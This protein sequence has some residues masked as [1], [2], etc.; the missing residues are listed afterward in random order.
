MW[1]FGAVLGGIAGAVASG[2]LGFVLGAL[3]GG[4]AGAAFVRNARI[5]ALEAR[6]DRL[7]AGIAVAATVAPAASAPQPAVPPEPESRYAPPPPSIEQE[8]P[9]SPE[10]A[11]AFQT[12]EPTAT[13]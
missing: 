2:G 12:V 8:P 11:R 10:P 13:E 5:R 4:F 9:V 3:A 7:E 6:V 1:F